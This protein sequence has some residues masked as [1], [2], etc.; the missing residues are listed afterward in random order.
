MW[1]YYGIAEQTE[2]TEQSCGTRSLCRTFQKTHHFLEKC[3]KTCHNNQQIKN[4]KVK[5]N[6]RIRKFRGKNED[7]MKK[8]GKMGSILRFSISKLCYIAI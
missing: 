8:F 1:S 4:K 2:Q 5:A 7:E 6:L 3:I